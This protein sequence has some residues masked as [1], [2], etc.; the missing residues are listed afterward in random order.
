[1]FDPKHST[2]P[3][4]RL[5][6]PDF[7][8]SSKLSV[9]CNLP[10]CDLEGK[11]TCGGCQ[12]AKYCSK[13]HQ[14]QDWSRHRRLCRPFRIV[15]SPGVGRHLV[16]TRDI[17]PGEVIMSEPPIT[18]G[19]RQYTSPVCLG[20]HAP[21][22]L[23]GYR[24]QTCSWPMCGPQCETL[25]LHL[26]ECQIFARAG[27]K[28]TSLKRKNGEAM[29]PE[30]EIEHP[31]YECVTPL[32]VCLSKLSSPENWKV[33]Q[34]M[35]THREVRKMSENHVHNKHNIVKFLL[36]HVKLAEHIP[37]ITEDDIFRANDVLDVNAFEIRGVGGS[38]RGLFPMTAMMNSSCSPNTQNSIDTDWVCRVRAVRVIK[39]G[40]EICDTYTATLCNTLYRR[41][42]LKNAK[43]FDCCC[44][45]CSDP[46]EFGSNFSTLVCR[47]PGCGGYVVS[48]DP[49]SPDSNWKCLKCGCEMPA[50]DVIAEQEDWEERIE[51][52]PRTIEDQKSLLDQL[53]LLY[54]PHHN[55]CVDVYYNMVPLFGHS[56]G[57]E[58]L[59]EEAESKLEMVEKCLSIMDKVIP[60][61]FRMRGMFLV[62]KYT[63]NLFLL[64]SKLE[65]KEISKSTFVRKVAGLRK[66]LEEAELILGFEPE[67]SI[68]G[69][70]LKSVKTFIKQLDQV[71]ADA[72]KTL[73]TS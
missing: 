53:L 21:V 10:N 25:P 48:S 54:H 60:G 71:V 44:P 20:C 43:Y 18:G 41:R 39:K 69:A 65:S 8:S 36:D 17:G 27:I 64:R 73:I 40:E 31:I 26:A 19:P 7:K 33:V 47:S 37:D 1:M 49:L 70:R 59:I 55:M 67:G 15:T 6:A 30:M 56:G 35:E 68:E 42:S 4:W 72:G 24:C 2:S 51:N 14:K 13:E 3:L 57:N 32:R 23:S 29:E 62:E 46:T 63:V 50:S 9:K 66:V 45:R 61:L 16:A 34:K 22:S 38:L 58:N 52:A 11:L 12:E 5:I 28:P